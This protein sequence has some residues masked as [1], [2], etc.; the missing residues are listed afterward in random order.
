MVKSKPHTTPEN[1]EQAI[2]ELEGIVAAME[3]DDLPLEQ[4]LASYER[5]ISLL[6]HCQSTLTAA[7]QKIRQLED[8]QLV[9]RPGEDQA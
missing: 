1:F 5:G 4:A 8:G 2:R 9:E 7:E 3:R 6:R